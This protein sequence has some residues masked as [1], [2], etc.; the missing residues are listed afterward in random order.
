MKKTIICILIVLLACFAAF[1]DTIDKVEYPELEKEFAFQPTMARY[2]AMGASGLASPTKLDSFYANPANLAIKR[3]FGLAVP[4]FSMTVYNIQKLVADPEAMEIVNKIAD[5]TASDE[6]KINLAT[7]YLG[8]LG[9]GRN[10]IAK[11]SGKP[12][13]LWGTL[14]SLTAIIVWA[15]WS[16]TGSRVDATGTKDPVCAIRQISATWRM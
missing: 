1:A 13:I 2:D 9:S 5:K 11:N 8:N 10:A 16:H 3:G 7:K 12:L 15:L 14:V 6:D 4:S